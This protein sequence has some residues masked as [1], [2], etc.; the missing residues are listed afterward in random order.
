MNCCTSASVSSLFIFSRAALTRVASIVAPQAVVNL[1][2]TLAGARQRPDAHVAG[3]AE[4]RSVAVPHFAP[5]PS[6]HSPSAQPLPAGVS[7]LLPALRPRA[8]ERAVAGQLAVLLEEQRQLAGVRGGVLGEQL[9]VGGVL[10]LEAL[11]H[12][13]GDLGGAGRRA[14]PCQVRLQVLLPPLG[15]FLQVGFGGHF[16]L[17]LLLTLLGYVPGIIHA[18]WVILRK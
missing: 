11:E 13:G 17:N 8:V 5:L 18:V 1:P 2:L 4:P 10:L 15:V 16:W 7:S 14:R 3:V 9:L 12:E 6:A